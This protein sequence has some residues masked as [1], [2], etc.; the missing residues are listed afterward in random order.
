MRDQAQDRSRLLRCER[1]WDVRSP[2]PAP[3]WMPPSY[4]QQ[5]QL[6]PQYQPQYI[7]SA[8]FAEAMTSLGWVRDPAA[9]PTPNSNVAPPF[10]TPPSADNSNMWDV[11]DLGMVLQHDDFTPTSFHVHS[12]PMA[13]EDHCFSAATP[14]IAPRT[15]V[16][17]PTAGMWL[18]DSGAS[19]RI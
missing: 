16:L 19:K 13:L 11:Y 5:A 14:L 1:R 10:P 12:V 15:T 3:P 7:Q 8:A 4:P 18:M 6:P 17:R 2:Y 9:G